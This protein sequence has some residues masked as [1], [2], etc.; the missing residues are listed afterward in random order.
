MAV[1]VTSEDCAFD[2]V[3]WGEAGEALAGI[4]RFPVSYRVFTPRVKG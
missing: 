4:L 2:G 1:C 3:G